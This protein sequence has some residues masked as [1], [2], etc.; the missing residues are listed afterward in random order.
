S[1]HAAIGAAVPRLRLRTKQ[2][3]SLPASQGGT[4]SV[5][6]DIDPPAQLGL[7]GRHT[8]DRHSARAT[9]L[10]AGFAFLTRLRTL[11][12]ASALWTLFVWGTRVR[13][14][15]N[16]DTLGG[17]EKALAFFVWGVFIPAGMP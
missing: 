9:R 4:T 17:G 1:D 10:R 2:G 15:G 13:N 12:V 8:V 14:V 16:D 11:V 7:H 3:L 5:G 6:A